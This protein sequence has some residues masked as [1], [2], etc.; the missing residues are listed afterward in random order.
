MRI[1]LAQ[2][3]PIVGD[4]AGNAGL[5]E[6]AARVAQAAGCDLVVCPE[7]A[8]CG[9]P[10]RDLLLQEGFVEACGRAARTLGEGLGGG[11]GEGMTLVLGLPLAADEAGYAA[12]RSRRLRNSLLAFRGGREVAR[13]HKRLLPT[14]DVFDEDRYFEPAGEACVI[15]VAGTLVGLSVCEDLWRGHDAGFADRYL[16]APDPLDALVAGGA[17]VVINPSASPFRLGMPARQAALLAHVARTR[18]VVVAAVNQVGGNDELVFDGRASVWAGDGGLIGQGPAFTTGLLVVDVDVATR[19]GRVVSGTGSLGGGSD[20]FASDDA[21]AELFA[22]LVLGV[23]DYA[24]KTG[25]NSAVLGLSGG[26]D[27]AVVAVVAAA[28]LGPQKVRGVAMPSRYSSAGSVSDAAALAGAVGML[29]ETIP[30][31]GAFSALLEALA[32][33][34][35]GR[36]P[37]VTEEN[38]QSRA[39]GTILMALSNKFG[40]LLLTTGNKSELAV[41]YCTLYGDMNGGLAVISDVPKTMVYRLAR[42]MNANWTRLGIDGL[43]EPPIPQAS[44]SKPPSAELRPN[45]TDQDSLPPYEVLDAILAAYVEEDLSIAEIVARGHAAA[46]VERV[47]RL[48]RISE[49]KRRQAPVGVRVTHRA[50]GRDWR[51]PIVNRYRDA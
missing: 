3:N 45:Q 50:F 15:D 9:Y 42:W 29:I 37:D 12:G 36:E 11:L 43:R 13:Y 10:P 28:A 24:R 23:R 16:D 22:A 6:G 39:R 35:G 31:E 19:S 49:Y 34:F 48:I 38:L 21:M 8:L 18:G 7:L 27:S 41:G 30:I 33:S 44:I 40:E 47:V 32:E 51:V 5:I 14:Y 4:I 20:G 17:Q 2:I 26:I 25:F 1:G 46:D